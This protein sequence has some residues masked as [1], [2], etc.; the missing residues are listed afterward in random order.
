MN[1]F[2]AVND[3]QLGICLRMLFAEN[4]QPAVQTVLNEKGKIEFHISIA[5]DDDL[6]EDLKQRYTILIS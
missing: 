5:A 6:L 2:L 1:Y 4:L 3:R